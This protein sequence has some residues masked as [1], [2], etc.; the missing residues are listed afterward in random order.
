[1][2]LKKNKCYCFKSRHRFFLIDSA[3]LLRC[4]NYLSGMNMV[5]VRPTSRYQ[6]RLNA[7]YFY[8]E[9]KNCFVQL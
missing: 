9:I 1:M 4:N 6:T 8:S 5:T 7:E 3:E 2:E